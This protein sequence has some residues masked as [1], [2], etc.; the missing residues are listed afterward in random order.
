MYHSQT[1]GRAPGAL[2]RRGRKMGGAV[3]DTTR[4]GNHG[5]QNQRTL[6]MRAH[7]DQGSYSCL[8]WVLCMYIMD[9]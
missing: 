3:R 8:T 4:I 5:P 1:L 6:L 9:E 2:W 7:R